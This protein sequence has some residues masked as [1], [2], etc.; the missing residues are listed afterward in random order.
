M[1]TNV[2]KITITAMLCAI[3]YVVM[4]VGRIPIVLFLKYDPK[5][6]VITLGGL[7]WGP[8]TS[9]AVSLAALLPVPQRLSIKKGIPCPAHYRG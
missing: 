2:R 1:N 8:L 9:C 7:I 6:V 3:S 4:A 5:D